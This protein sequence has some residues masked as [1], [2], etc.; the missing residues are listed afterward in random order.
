MEKPKLV[1]LGHA[2]LSTAIHLFLGVVFCA[3][4]FFAHLLVM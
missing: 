1:D 3:F 2:I 4:F